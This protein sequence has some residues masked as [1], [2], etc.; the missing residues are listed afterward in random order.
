MTKKIRK[1][2]EQVLSRYRRKH[3]AILA[4]IAKVGFICKGNISERL[5]LCGNPTCSCHTDPKKRHGPYYQLSWKE[6]GKTLSH[7]ID[8]KDLH[9]YRQWIKN[10]QT[11][12][13]LVEELDGLSKKA[14]EEIRAL[15][16]P[17][18][19]KNKRQAKST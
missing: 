18:I 12:I 8:Q 3:E 14:T 19:P 13:D 1:E 15:N 17:R 5:T 10:R 4:R 6:K 2:V 11:L 7:L 9:L 16:N